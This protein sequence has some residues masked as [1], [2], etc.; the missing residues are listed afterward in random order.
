MTSSSDQ[1]IALRKSR[2]LASPSDTATA[3]DALAMPDDCELVGGTFVVFAWQR[4]P[5]ILQVNL[6][7][8]CWG[9]HRSGA[10]ELV[11]EEHGLTHSPQLHHINSKLVSDTQW[12]WLR[13]IFIVVRRLFDANEACDTV[14]K[15]HWLNVVECRLAYDVMLRQCHRYHVNLYPTG[16]FAWHPPEALRY[17]TRCVVWWY[18]R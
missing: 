6:T 16:S 2:R 8:Y 14:R 4:R 18:G 7:Q 15:V 1:T 9:G 13:E 3:A 10:L 11:L 5:C 12:S 17:G